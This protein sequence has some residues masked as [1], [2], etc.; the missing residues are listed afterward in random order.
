MPTKC[1]DMHIGAGGDRGDLLKT[2]VKA[3]RDDFLDL[4]IT[5]SLWE[6]FV[7]QRA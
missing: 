2:R 5:D 1:I 4:E 7:A 6:N 3:V